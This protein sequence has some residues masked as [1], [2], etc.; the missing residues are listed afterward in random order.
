MPDGNGYK[1]DDFYRANAT[2][3]YFKQKLN[4]LLKSKDPKA[5]EDFANGVVIARQK[6][7]STEDVAK[8][9]EEHPFNA[10]LSQDEIKKELGKD[11]YGKYLQALNF[12]T[13]Y[14]R[15]DFDPAAIKGNIENAQDLTAYNYGKRFS[16]IPL[17]TSLNISSPD[18]K[19]TYQRRAIYNA[20][21]GMPEIV[22]Y[23]DKSLLVQ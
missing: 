10:Y 21:T 22:E 4:P 5:Y 1:D 15:K 8:Y 11:D 17:T 6:A 19:K 7:K 13:N 20:K 23:G 12:I 18:G 14:G 2:I 9:I 3:A 16:S